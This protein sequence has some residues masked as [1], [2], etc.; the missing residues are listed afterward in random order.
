VIVTRFPFHMFPLHDPIHR[1]ATPVYNESHLYCPF[2]CCNKWNT[3]IRSHTAKR[4]IKILRVTADYYSRILLYSWSQV[5]GSLRPT[6][7]WITKMW[8]QIHSRTDIQNVQAVCCDRLVNR[9]HPLGQSPV[10]RVLLNT[11]K[12]QNVIINSESYRLEALMWES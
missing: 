12:I 6:R 3:Y 5:L 9:D 4:R 8:I 11:L 2:L 10:K 1:N 7:Y